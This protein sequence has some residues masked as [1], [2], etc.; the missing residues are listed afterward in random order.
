[1]RGGHERNSNWWNY[2]WHNCRR[3]WRRDAVTGVALYAEG[4]ENG[5]NT[6]VDVTAGLSAVSVVSSRA[7]RIAHVLFKRPNLTRKSLGPVRAWAWGK[8]ASGLSG[9]RGPERTAF[10]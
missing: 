10:G 8:F 1:M 9:I 4:R 3:C 5:G 6:A 7:L 2:F